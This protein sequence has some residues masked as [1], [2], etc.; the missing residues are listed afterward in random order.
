MTNAFVY[1]PVNE[2]DVWHTDFFSEGTL[3]LV[4]GKK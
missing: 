1:D 2:N 3:V 4:K